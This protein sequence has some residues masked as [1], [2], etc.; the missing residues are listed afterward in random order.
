MEP[1]TLSLPKKTAQLC[2]PTVRIFKSADDVTPQ[3][4]EIS[5][6]YVS[7]IHHSETF[8]SEVEN[9]YILQRLLNESFTTAQ[10]SSSFAKIDFHDF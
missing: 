7:F 6:I 9:I 5:L 1:Q 3:L 8:H 10:C 2:N 4:Q